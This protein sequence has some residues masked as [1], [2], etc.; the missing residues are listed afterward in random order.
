MY[1]YLSSHLLGDIFHSIASPY[2]SAGGLLFSEVY[3]IKGEKYQQ[4]TLTH[5]TRHA[6]LSKPL[7]TKS[8]SF[9]Y[10]LTLPEVT[11]CQQGRIY[12]WDFLFIPSFFL[13]LSS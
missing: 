5:S 9:T 2:A 1:T 8:R 7:E 11:H 12:L 6:F 13:R 4:K 3:L 10:A